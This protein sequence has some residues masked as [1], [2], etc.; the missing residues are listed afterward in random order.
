MNPV[1]RYCRA[2]L[3]GLCG[4]LALIPTPASAVAE[5]YRTEVELSTKEIGSKEVTL[6]DLVA[7]AIRAS[8]HADVAFVVA[9][10]FSD[11]A[12]IIKP[13]SFEMSDL[14]KTLEYKNETITIVKLT[15]DQIHAALEHGLYLYP[16]TNSS[17]LQTSGL[18]MTVDADAE[19]EKRVSAIKVGGEPLVAGKSYHVAM[20][21]TLAL[22]TLA[23]S[24]IWKKSDIEKDTGKTLEA[25]L[26]A[27]LTDHHVVSRGE[28]RLI[29][30]GGPKESVHG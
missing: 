5:T 10:A 30:K 1:S 4:L 24:K 15:G 20:S 29:S 18:T 17:F 8:A 19:G 2:V 12:A 23:Y 21:N 28:D 6:G 3:I 14:L 25:A 27:Y 7:D 26:I 11:T 13:G 16:K 22:G 9:A